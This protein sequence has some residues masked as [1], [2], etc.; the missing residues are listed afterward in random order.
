M[1]E[2]GGVSGIYAGEV[3]INLRTVQFKQIN[4]GLKFA[5]TLKLVFCT[6]LSQITCD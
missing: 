4:L 3:C 2:T 1:A 6:F 5:I